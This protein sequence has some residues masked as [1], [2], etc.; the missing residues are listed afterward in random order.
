MFLAN[1]RLFSAK[2]EAL[3]GKF[4]SLKWEAKDTYLIMPGT[5]YF[6]TDVLE[7]IIFVC[8]ERLAE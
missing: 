2:S 1:N 5:I 6:F 4:I 3:S 7:F 8:G